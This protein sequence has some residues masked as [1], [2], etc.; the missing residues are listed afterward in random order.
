MRPLLSVLALMAVCGAHAESRLYLLSQ[1]DWGQKTGFYLDLEGDK[2]ETLP[3][4]LGVGDGQQW[5]FARV[6]PGFVTGRDYIIRATVGPQASSL[7]LDGKPVG[8][9]ARVWKP[10]TQPLVADDAPSWAKGPADWLAVMT[11]ASVE[12]VGDGKPV[13]KYAFDLSQQVPTALRFFEAGSPQRAALE[14]RPGDTLTVEIKLQ[15]LSP[16]LRKYA[17]FID[18][19]GQARAADF[20]EKV[21]S[22]ADLKADIAAEDAQLAKMPPSPE[23]DA[24]GGYRAAP[25]KETPT[26]FFRSLK[27]DGKW[28]LIS[29]EG[30]PCFFLGVCGPPALSWETTPVTGREYLFES[31]PP[32][33][34][35]FAAVWARDCWGT[36]DGTE[37][38][39][40]YAAN[41]IRK[42]GDNWQQQATDRALRRMQSLGLQGGKWGTGVPLAE[43]PVLRRSDVPNLVKHPD[44]FDEAT[45]QRLRESLTKQ[46]TPRLQ[47]PR[48]V[49]WSFGNEYD[50][51]I[52]R[53]EMAE[54]MNKT[55]SAARPALVQY[56]L[57]ELYGGDLAKLAKAWQVEAADEAA[58]LASTPKVPDADLEK[59]RLHYEARYH[60]FIYKTVKQI[61]PN[62][63]Y[64]GFWIVPGWW[65]SPEDWAATTPFCDVIGYDR[66]SREF[67][68][69]R[70]AGL[71]A[72]SDKPALCGEFSL[73]STYEGKRGFGRYG[74]WTRDEQEAGELYTGWVRD[75]TADPHCV[76]LIWF[77]YR[78]QPLTGRGPGRGDQLVYG[79]HYAF[80]LVTET[81]RLKWPLAR[82]IREA[83]AKAAQW[84]LGR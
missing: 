45:Q 36:N 33:E 30:N 2:L 41:L 17:P 10:S 83:S 1:Y 52:T 57:R 32:K 20:P 78:D 22:E 18:A 25:W 38:A 35:P 58:L 37:Y 73:P 21:K 11:T 50:E 46:I 3:L 66:Y 60:E 61:D 84:R 77:I 44:V 80:G 82:A 7:E 4:I 75:A 27:R 69:E 74:T 13:T 31:L 53:A 42:Y 19:F 43:T 71:L 76:G 28:W 49:G 26:G 51:L 40:L 54:V 48:V 70:L 23:F 55:Q 72:Q 5:E 56:A 79:E 9:M 47:D 59:M 64:L 34:G 62:H 12:V 67:S 81:D 15:F 65:E 8:E 63:L 39:C 68:D 16:D 14:T 29:P 24:Y 6:A